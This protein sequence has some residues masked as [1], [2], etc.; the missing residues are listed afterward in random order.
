MNQNEHPVHGEQM[1]HTTHPPAP[2]AADHRAHGAPDDGTGPRAGHGRQHAEAAL[3][4]HTGHAPSGGGH[5]HAAMMSDPRMAAA[6]ERDM[7]NRFLVSFL[8]TIPVILYSE[9]GRTVF[10]DIP[11]TPFGLSMEW[12]GFILSTPVVLYG[13]WVFLVGSYDALRSLRLDMSVLI[14]TGVAAAYL[15]SVGV[16][17]T[18]GGEVFY[19]AAAMLITFVLFGH[20]MEMR[21]R[22]GTTDALR[23]L[24]TLVPEKALVLRDGQEVEVDT[25][26]VVPGDSVRIRPGQR[27]PVDG[28]IIEGRSTIDESLVT[29]ESLPVERVEGDDVVAGSVN[30]DGLLLIE[31]VGTGSETV[32]GR[33]ID[34]VQNAQASKA[35]AQRLADRAA[36][37]LVIV[38]VGSGLVTFAAWMAFDGDT[39]TALRFA[40]AAVVIACP[41]ALG[42]ATPTAVAVGTGL[43]ARHKVLIKDAATLE[44]VSRVDAIVLDKTGTV[45][46]GKPQVVELAPAPGWEK[47]NL[48]RFAAA[49]EQSST[50]PL[51]EAVVSATHSYELHQLPGFAEAENVPGYGAKGLVEGKQVLVGSLDLLAREGVDASALQAPA[52]EIATAGRTVVAVAVGGEPAGLIALADIVR[53]SAAGTV[54]AL[55]DE[56]IEVALLTGDNEGTARAVASQVGISRVFANVKP[57][58]KADY[59]RKL[60][61]EGKIVA[62]VGDGVNDAPALAAADVGIAIGAGTDVAIETA[63]IVLMRSDPVDILKAIDLSKATVRK[64]KQNLFWA[65]IYNLLAIP[66]AAGIL[67]T[68]TGFQIRPEFAALLMSLSS[69]IVATNAVLLRRQGTHMEEVEREAQ[70]VQRSLRVPATSGSAS[71]R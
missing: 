12:M 43:G 41:D 18:G 36:A 6:M 16:T 61:A 44:R 53:P 60:Q 55:Q 2:S 66:L 46:E 65:S 14:T 56:G 52:A 71:V 40:I 64:M 10:G 20:W 50:H 45:T 3:E 1:D 9:L 57:A 35:P 33:I 38:A 28:K 59:V 70:A 17:F 21:S 4:A 29:G 67:Y 15:Y 5:D 8:L 42:L 63:S 25:A 49:L 68:S 32:L 26:E 23:A 39:T 22:R 48:L 7:R 27:V 24:L 30:G 51:A 31:A 58:D 47:K 37:I 54:R 62:M 34:L 19:E 13:G 11:P 69:I